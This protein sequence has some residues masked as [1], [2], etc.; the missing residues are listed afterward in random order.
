MNRSLSLDEVIARD[1]EREKKAEQMGKKLAEIYERNEQRLKIQAKWNFR[2]KRNVVNHTFN[3][4]RRSISFQQFMELERV[5]YEQRIYAKQRAD[6][7][8]RPIETKSKNYFFRLT[9]KPESQS[10]NICLEPTF[11]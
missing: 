5:K 10:N 7:Y 3:N 6:R 2:S 8:I 1:Y 4:I 9:T 11:Q